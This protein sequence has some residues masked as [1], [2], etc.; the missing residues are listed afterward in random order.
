[1]LIR[2]SR[3][4]SCLWQ[5]NQDTPLNGEHRGRNQPNDII[6][7]MSKLHCDE[8]FLPVKN[9]ADDEP[10]CDA[11]DGL[12]QP[13]RV[14]LHVVEPPVEGGDLPADL[15]AAVEEDA[16]H[17]REEERLTLPPVLQVDKDIEEGEQG[18]SKAGGDEN[19]GDAPEVLVD[20]HPAALLAAT[21]EQGTQGSCDKRPS[22]PTSQPVPMPRENLND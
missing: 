6:P 18:E 17:S 1:M 10:K 5:P 11:P 3:F 19:E 8:Y 20:G 15:V 22:C 14:C 12:R 13:G 7:P 9:K 16:V 21:T 2:V 4:V